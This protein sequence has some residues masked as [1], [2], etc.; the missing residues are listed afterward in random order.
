MRPQGPAVAPGARGRNPSAG[1]GAA[2]GP[3][4]PLLF[5][6]AK[7]VLAHAAGAR[8]LVAQ[9]A[10]PDEQVVR[11]VDVAGEAFGEQPLQLELDRRD[12]LRVEQLAKVLAAKQLGEPVAVERQRRGAALG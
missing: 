2:D 1:P 4:P 6:S 10:Q 12:R 5:E 8:L 11:F 7:P 3:R 9:V